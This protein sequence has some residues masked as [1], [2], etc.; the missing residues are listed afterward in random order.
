ML[1]G[2]GV[3]GETIMLYDG[4][5]AIG[6]VVVGAGGTSSKT[7]SLSSGTHTLTATQKLVAGVTSAASAARTVTV[8][9]H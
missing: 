4:S 3:A 6:T 5:T 2:T 1:S 9:S 7:V 8:P